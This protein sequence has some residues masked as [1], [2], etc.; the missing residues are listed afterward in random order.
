AQVSMIRSRRVLSA[1]IAEP[2]VRALSVV[3]RKE[4]PVTWLQQK[5]EVD[6]AEGPEVLRIA[7]TG[8]NAKEL[9]TIVN[10]VADAYLREF[11]ELQQGKAKGRLAQLK[12]SRG[13][14]DTR[15]QSL[16][17]TLAAADASAVAH[18]SAEQSSQLRVADEQQ[19]SDEKELVNAES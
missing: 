9:T 13:E 8:E 1:A 14:F 12:K 4:E 17:K 7:M 3:Q 6:Y 15:L 10:A 19:R 11:A 5:L 18:Q 16:K 2:E